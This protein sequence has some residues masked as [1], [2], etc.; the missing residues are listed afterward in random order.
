[1][2]P[3][4]GIKGRLYYTTFFCDG[5]VEPEC[6]ICA[7]HYSLKCGVCLLPNEGLFRRETRQTL[8]MLV[9]LSGAKLVKLLGTF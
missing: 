4:E 7:S 5:L 1:M 6:R 8:E 3:T 2:M 9:R